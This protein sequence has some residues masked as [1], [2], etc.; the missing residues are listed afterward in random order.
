MRPQG[1]GDAAMICPQ[2]G[3]ALIGWEGGEEDENALRDKVGKPL[4]PLQP[5]RLLPLPRGL[6][7][8]LLT[9]LPLVLLPHELQ[10]VIDR[11]LRGGGGR[12]GGGSQ[13]WWW[14]WCERGT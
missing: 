10:L 2:D 11:G 14:W 13:G 4:R 12:R 5:A 1:G 6:P 8:L 9:L 7:R 3:R